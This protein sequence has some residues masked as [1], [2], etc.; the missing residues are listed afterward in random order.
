MEYFSV[1]AENG[2][3]GRAAEALGLSQPALSKSLG[4]LERSVGAKLV[5]RTPKGVDLTAA[6]TALLSRVRRLRLALDDIAQE[7]ADIGHGRAGHLRI[8][9]VL[10]FIRYPVSAACKTLFV[11]APNV[12]FAVTIE[13]TDALLSA[14]RNGELDL[15]VGPITGSLGDDFVEEHLF[16]DEFVVITSVNHRLASRKRVTITDLAQE[17]WVILA[18][19]SP[20]TQRMRRGYEESGLPPPRIAVVTGSL[21]LRDYLASF[22]NLLGYSSTRVAR[23]ASP[24]VRFAELRVKELERIRRVGVIYRN[25]SYVSPAARRFIEILK[26]TAKE[27]APGKP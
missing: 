24:E 17:R 25:D 11:E 22:T 9:V 13:P 4:R 15:V 3:I 18:A 10:G 7:A 2:H 5:K 14:L 16:E 12:T 21:A 6:G 8:G 20:A 1:V 23:E 27:V 26:K 19:N